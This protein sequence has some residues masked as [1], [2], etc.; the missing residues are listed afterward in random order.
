[1]PPAGAS[2]RRYAA[3]LSAVAVALLLCAGGAA[4]VSVGNLGAERRAVEDVNT[5]ISA[6]TVLLLAVLDA[7]PGQRGF[8][9][10]GED[11]YL[12]PY[13]SA[14]DRVADDLAALREAVTDSPSLQAR[15]P[16]I[17]RIVEDRLGALSRTVELAR[18]GDRQAALD[19]VRSGEG[20]RSMDALRGA[21]AE[22]E[23]VARRGLAGRL[24]GAQRS[25]TLGVL[26]LGLAGL[27]ALL[28]GGL[29]AVLLLR[30]ADARIEESEQHHRHSL[31]LN[32]QVAWTADAEGRITDFS[33][34]WLELTGLTREQ[35]LGHGWQQVPHP[36][37]LA[38]MAKAWSHAAA[39]GQPYDIEHRIRLAD[40]GWRWMRSRAWPRVDGRGRI[41]RW[42]G[43]TEDIEERR[44]AEARQRGLEAE[45][46]HAGRVSTLGEA[47][48]ALAHELNQ[49]LAAVAHYVEGCEMLLSARGAAAIQEVLGGLEGAS[50]QAERA[51]EIVRR[52]RRF[53]RKDTATAHHLPTDPAELVRDAVPLGAGGARDAGVTVHCDLP[54]R[55]PEVAVDRVEIQQVVVNLVRNA[56]EAMTE[57]DAFDAAATREV[58]ISARVVTAQA[59]KRQVEVAVADSG[60]GLPTEIAG[61]PFR[62][63]ATTRS[64]GLGLGLSICRSIVEAHGGAI[65]AAANP[66]GGATFF[67]R[68]PVLET[69][70]VASLVK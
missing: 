14:Q 30:R 22:L 58:R 33:R 48:A 41:I 6:A 43:V 24:A 13:R 40:G 52:L 68:L 35:A 45:L 69:V 62:P 32:P 25:A 60:L 3:A 64:G 49:P 27:L 63:F 66:G 2:I 26:G 15:L 16:A 18:A 7:E 38:A 34:R 11:R 5:T 20:K 44:A 19:I 42:Y 47:A 70:P 4:W 1:M 54:E 37:D 17:E 9:L 29:A 12:E 50:A 39:T 56:I 65:A 67:F 31:D 61:D 23:A 36:D 53:V 59:G 57:G 51:A 46:W 8:L 21:L 55:L 28:A 10:S